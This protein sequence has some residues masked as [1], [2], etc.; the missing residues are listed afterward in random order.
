MFDSLKKLFRRSS[1]NAEQ[2][3]NNGA[4]VVDVRTPFEFKNG[5]LA[6][7]RNIPLDAL[8][9]KIGELKK[10]NK[11]IITVCRSGSRSSMAKD[12]L[13]AAG[14]DAYNGGAWTNF[15]TAG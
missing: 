2:L 8:P 11:T 1:A 5:H 15:K 4:V 10:L 14:V 13:A 6:G 3:L 7:S 12:M 9:D